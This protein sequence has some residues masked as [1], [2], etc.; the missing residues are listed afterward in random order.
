MLQVGEL[1]PMSRVFENTK[2]EVDRMKGGERQRG[3][4]PQS[5]SSSLCK[6][7]GAFHISL[8]F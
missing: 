1:V 4:G 3:A 6:V 7:P 8:K 5:P 2:A